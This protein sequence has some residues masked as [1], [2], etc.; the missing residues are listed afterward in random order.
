MKNKIIKIKMSLGVEWVEI[1]RQAASEEVRRE[2]RK[3]E[4]AREEDGRGKEGRKERRN[5]KQNSLKGFNR[6][7]YY[8]QAA[9]KEEKRRGRK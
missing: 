7:K 2:K 1:Y 6:C 4:E 8:R 9:R 3:E 5:R